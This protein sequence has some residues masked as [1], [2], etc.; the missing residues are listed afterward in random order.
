MIMWFFAIF[1]Q[2]DC[3]LMWSLQ[4]LVRKSYCVLIRN[5]MGCA[6]SVELDEWQVSAQRLRSTLNQPLRY[7][8]TS[9]KSCKLASQLCL[10]IYKPSSNYGNIL[11][12]FLFDLT[13]SM[14]LLQLHSFWYCLHHWG[15]MGFSHFYQLQSYATLQPLK[16]RFVPGRQTTSS[17]ECIA[18]FW[19][20]NELS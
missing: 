16:L 4:V 2:C 9:H 6:C 14:D 19:P 18:Y 1:E 12:C 13:D 8:Y 7:I 17:D 3:Y 10:F 11:V 15:T 5:G 20:F